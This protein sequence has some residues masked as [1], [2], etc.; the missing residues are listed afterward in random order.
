[1]PGTLATFQPGEVRTC[2][3]CHGINDIGQNG[4][5]PPENEPEALRSLLQYLKGQGAP[6]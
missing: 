3:S 6:L 5:T 1:M 2:T 4:A